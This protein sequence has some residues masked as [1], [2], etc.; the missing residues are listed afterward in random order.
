MTA[1]AKLVVDTSLEGIHTDAA[2]LPVYIALLEMLT[3]HL[4]VTAKTVED[5]THELSTKFQAIARDIGEQSAQLQK[6]IE[7]ATYI[8]CDG[9]KTSV[10][11]FM[12]DFSKLLGGTVGKIINISKL[13]MTMVYNM[14]EAI[15][16]IAAIEAFIDRVQKINRQTNLL[17][18]NA[19]IEAERAGEAGRGFAVVASEV[20]ILSKEISQLS[21]EMRTK[22]NAVSE[23]VRTSYAT[24]KDVATTD[25]S[26]NIN[27]Q[28][29]LQS[30]T[31]TMLKQNEDFRGQL[32]A[33]SDTS[34]QVSNAIMQIVVGMQFQDRNTQHIQNAV[35]SLQ[36]ATDYLRLLAKEAAPPPEAGLPPRAREITEDLLEHFMLSEFRHKL[37]EHLLASG[38]I[39]PDDPLTQAMRVKHAGEVA[40]KHSEDHHIELF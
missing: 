22:I 18:L 17:A 20:K 21:F 36:Q 5:I 28:D 34:K 40:A 39:R 33:T 7:M 11:D 15:K 12:N 1:V 9:K 30:L 14:D 13:A 8:S 37:L 10:T 19:N 2:A 31:S 27:A 24:L 32:A 16:N 25:M 3:G 26:D 6:V 38:I 35:S 29:T 23:S 4:P